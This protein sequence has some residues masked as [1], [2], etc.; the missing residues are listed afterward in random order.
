VLAHDNGLDGGLFMSG[1]A[2]A[3][4]PRS[5]CGG[6]RSPACPAASGYPTHAGTLPFE[7]AEATRLL[8]RSALA[9]IL[10]VHPG[11]KRE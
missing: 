8:L 6:I 7:E 3:R 10:R 11:E 1:S 5:P 9:D 4:G 2:A